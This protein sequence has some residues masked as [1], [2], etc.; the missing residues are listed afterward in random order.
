[1]LQ[2]LLAKANAMQV[3]AAS[4]PKKIQ[5]ALF[6]RS[7]WTIPDDTD[8]GISFGEAVEVGVGYMEM[9]VVDL[10]P[11]PNRK[12]EIRGGY[13][14]VG[15]GIGEISKAQS[16]VEKILKALPKK[17]KPSSDLVAM[18]GGSITQFI[19]GVTQ[20]QPQLEVN[21]FK[22]S[23]WIY[24]HIGAEVAILAGDVGLMFLVDQ[25]K[26]ISIKNALLATN[27]LTLPMLLGDLIANC[28]AWAPYYGTSVGLGAGGK[29]AVRIVQTVQMNAAAN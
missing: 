24:V 4:I 3:A 1:M 27:P 28:K 21:D 7:G 5:N 2:E 14:E 15:V 12:Y 26:A 10:R 29:A 18:P 6:R 13:G 9:D 25:E 22:N 23:S 20:S 19:M 16:I 17:I 8:T 11:S